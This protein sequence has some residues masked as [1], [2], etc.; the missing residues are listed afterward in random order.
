MPCR[1]SVA[2]PV[3]A[4][5]LALAGPGAAQTK[6]LT[7]DDLFDPARKI[8]A[9]GIV[10]TGI[11][12]LDDTR[13]LW[14]KRVDEDTADWLTVDVERGTSAPF[15]DAA[16]LEAAITALPGIGPGDAKRLA[17]PRSF[18]FGPDR[19]AAVITVAGDLFHYAFATGTLTRLTSDPAEERDA[20]FSPNGAM[21]AFTRGNNL[22]VVDV[23]TQ[24]ERALTVD[25][26]PQL[27][28]GRLDW[29]YQEE[30]YGRGTHRAF[31][32][33]PDSTRLA[34]LQLDER[35]VAEFTLVNHLPSWQELEVFDYPKPGDPNPLVRLGVA[36]ASGG[37]VTW[38]DTAKYSARE[39][40]IVD[41]SWTTDGGQVVYQLQDREQTW[42]DLN[43]G[44]P[45][46]GETRTLL[47][48]TTKAWVEPHGAPRWMKDGTFLWRGERDGWLH[49]YRYKADGT[50]L[51]QVT[52]GEWEVRS[53]HGVDEQGGWIYFSGTERSHI[54]SDVYRVK[55]DGSGLT[56]LSSAPGTHTASFNPSFSAYVDV[57]SDLTT[58]PQTRLH[59][60]DGTE[61]RVLE[62]NALPALADYTL[63]KPELLQVKARDG[64]VM[65]A[66]L[67]KPPDFDP[68]RKYPSTS[69][70]TPALTRRRC[71]TRGEG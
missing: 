63:S 50:P 38:I 5:V 4:G 52:R 45:T 10:P 18:V 35:P 56:R 70:L 67:L 21:V 7:L 6:R 23:A 16:A 41:V 29:V 58:P 25:G 19:R 62:R 46:T 71:A 39:H 14:P 31:W 59:R 42:L 37:A 15:Y 32:W 26:G 66:M 13:Y 28:N 51:G 68:S 47:R 8:D 49:L 61:V 30:I 69:R 54:G 60:A 9:T 53:L 34:F 48:E 24:R 40:L 1:V 57:W 3:I 33:S 20:A 64:F 17:R 36:R 12:W 22:V 27:L 2:V 43:V 55:I 11:T 44:H 65:E